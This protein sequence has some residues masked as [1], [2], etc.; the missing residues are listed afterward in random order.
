MVK[1]AT[2][3]VNLIQNAMGIQQTGP[4][5]VIVPADPIIWDESTSYEYL[6]LVA[7]TDFGQSY[8]SK[9]DVPA[10]TPLTNEDYWIPVAR[11]NAQLAAIQKELGEKA[12]SSDVSAIQT[13]VNELTH[14][15]YLVV[16]GDSFSVDDGTS[17]SSEGPLWYRYVAMQYNLT[18]KPYALK[19]TGFV[20][21]GSKNFS[22]QLNTAKAEL[23]A[24]YVDM[25]CVLGGW[26]DL[27]Q[28]NTG[29]VLIDAVRT[30]CNDIKSSFPK[31]Q[32]I[33]AGCNTMQ[34]GVITKN[35]STMTVTK[36]IENG[37]K[38]SNGAAFIDIHMLNLLQDSYFGAYGGHHPNSYGEK[39]FATAII[40]RMA[41]QAATL[42]SFKNELEIEGGTLNSAF[43]ELS[44]TN[45]ANIHLNFTSDSDGGN[46]TINLPEGL[47][48]SPVAY[49]AISIN[50]D[51]CYALVSSNPTNNKV[52]FYNTKA[53]TTYGGTFSTV[54]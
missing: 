12:D 52:T 3:D 16:I 9:K 14:E 39:T 8:V 31:A 46:V 27:I 41:L 1:M 25:V 51:V 48:M 49:V 32:I 24:D 7:S 22:G 21:G 10:G 33:V 38:T 47:D 42:S 19:G 43:L 36:Q 54:V 15:R 40:S 17:T 6:T 23:D 28:G 5:T 20:T 29:Q 4:R 50:G 45:I 34:N 11:Y 26:N 37:V 53:N 35:N 18:S 13:T 30:L 2:C 44:N